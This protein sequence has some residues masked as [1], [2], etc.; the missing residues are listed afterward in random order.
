MA[1]DKP[2]RLLWLFITGI[3]A[4]PQNKLDWYRLGG[5]PF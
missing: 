3:V 2:Q 1:L 4:N 5:E